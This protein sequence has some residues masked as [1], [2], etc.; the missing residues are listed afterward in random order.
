MVHIC[1]SSS[2]WARFCRAISTRFGQREFT[3][4]K[5][6]GLFSLCFEHVETL[7][8]GACSA[9]SP[10]SF[11]AIPLVSKEPWRCIAGEVD[12]DDRPLAEMT[13]SNH[14][15]RRLASVH[16]VTK[17]LSPSNWPESKT[18]LQ[19]GL[20][21]AVGAGFSWDAVEDEMRI[22]GL[23]PWYPRHSGDPI[24]LADEKELRAVTIPQSP[25]KISGD[26]SK[27]RYYFLVGKL[28]K[29]YFYVSSLGLDWA[30]IA[31]FIISILFARFL[32]FSTIFHGDHATNSSQT[33]SIGLGS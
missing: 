30:P 17:S 7:P 28:T 22:G 26:L 10:G 21:D 2:G 31:P 5:P 19:L 32:G 13:D 14:N 15:T 24:L 23:R 25:T 8:V 16:S 9:S 11:R 12:W 3:L 6:W 20:H 27:T 33:S 4:P 1:L 29:G 18:E